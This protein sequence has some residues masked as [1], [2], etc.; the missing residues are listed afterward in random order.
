MTIRCLHTADLHLDAPFPNWG[1]K[2]GVRR[3]D[4]LKTFE[5][6]VTLAIKNDVQLLLISGDLFDSPHPEA[7]TV[8]RV[9]T[10]LRRL[11]DR[12]ITPV[13]LPGTHDPFAPKNSIYRRENFPGILLSE[14]QLSEPVHLSLKGGDCY[15]YGFAYQ[16]GKTEE[17]LPSM[18]RRDLPGYHIGLLHGSRRGSLE[19]DYRHK[20]LPFDISDLVALRLDYIALGHYH[21]FSVLQDES[22]RNIAAYPGSPEGKR[23]GED[24][25][26]YCALVTLD[27]GGVK[28]EALEVNTRTL[29]QKEIDLSG[30]VTQEGA[31]AEIRRFASPDLILRSRL[32]GTVE[33]PLTLPALLAACRDDFFWLELLDS[34]RLYDSAYAR[35]IEHEE[36][37]RGLFVRR[38]RR[39]IEESP[40]ERRPVVEEA[41]REVLARFTATGGER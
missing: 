29:A 25:P 21:T 23:F 14:A 35:R 22:A 28:I 32:T 15:L 17:L 33:I 12:G 31:I 20:D 16:S 40:P 5:R 3:A 8:S 10:E 18:Q 26:R 1:E 11:V 34:T 30:I 39:L 19:W 41:F 9:Q 13:L 6:I 38:M 24:G 36:T 2:E 37:V 7:A 27:T 4:L